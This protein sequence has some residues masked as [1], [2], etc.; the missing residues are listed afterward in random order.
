[1]EPERRRPRI[2][3]ATLID[4]WLFH[5]AHRQWRDSIRFRG[6]WWDNDD[7]WAWA[8]L[9]IRLWR[10]VT[11]ARPGPR[12][13]RIIGEVAFQAHRRITHSD[14]VSALRER[15]TAF[16]DR[17]QPEDMDAQD[18]AAQHLFLVI[19]IQRGMVEEAAA[20]VRAIRAWRD[21]TFIG[22]RRWAAQLDL[23]RDLP[24]RAV[25]R[26]V[27]ALFLGDQDR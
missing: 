25:V 6:G 21:W 5:E 10:T 9:A 2:S 23:L 14:E 20:L 15:L 27:I 4:T 12:L 1:M 19:G 18:H 11:P 24:F 22:A 13:H 3:V 7:A 26:R 16:L 8:S 17:G